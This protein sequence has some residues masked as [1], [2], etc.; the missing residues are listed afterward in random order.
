MSCE[1]QVPYAVMNYRTLVKED[2]F[3]VDHTR[4]LRELEKY[5]T[6]A[7]MRPKRFGKSLWVSMLEHYYDV[8]FK[9]RFPELF[10][11]TDIG[12]NPTPTTTRSAAG[13]TA[14]RPHVLHGG[15]P[16]HAGRPLQRLQCRDGRQP[17]SKSLGHG[18]LFTDRS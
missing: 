5:Q 12:R 14:R 10:G 17:P 16:D 7:F 1:R 15:P 13:P 6:P 8:R 18:G 3:F 2:F 9:D 11:K 4:Y